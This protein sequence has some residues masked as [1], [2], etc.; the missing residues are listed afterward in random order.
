MNHVSHRSTDEWFYRQCERYSLCTL[1]QLN[2]AECFVTE[3]PDLYMSAVDIL[4]RVGNVNTPTKKL[5][6]LLDAAK[7]VVSKMKEVC[8][9]ASVNSDEFL[10]VWIWVVVNTK[11]FNLVRTP[12]ISLRHSYLCCYCPDS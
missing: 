11:L 12:S 4:R 6:L 3:D 5:K 7:S 8:P 9:S 10:P 2:T 1:V